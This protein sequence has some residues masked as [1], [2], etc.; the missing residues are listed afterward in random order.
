MTRGELKF[1]LA[2]PTLPHTATAAEA[3]VNVQMDA[4]GHARDEQRSREACTR[5]GAERIRNR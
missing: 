1:S 5:T 2:G 3:R 4:V